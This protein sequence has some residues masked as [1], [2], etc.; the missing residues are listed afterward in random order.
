MIN[1]KTI[2]SS[3]DDK[4]TLLKWLKKV[5]KALAE[6]VLED[7]E[8]VT[9]D[10]THI[11]LVFKFE[12][13]TEIETSSITLPRGLKG[14]TGATGEAGPQGPQGPKGDDG[15]DAEVTAENV[16]AVT[17][18][19][20]TIVVD[21]AEDEEHIEIHLDADVVAKIENALQLPLNPPTTEKIVA[22]GTNGA[23]KLIDIPKLY[24]HNI[25]FK[26]YEQE[27]VN[28]M[29]SII[30]SKS[31]AYTSADFV[32]GIDIPLTRF[33]SL[34]SFV[35]SEVM[36]SKLYTAL[37]LDGDNILHLIGFES[38]PTDTPWFQSYHGQLI[39]TGNFF[40]DEVTEL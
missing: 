3:F 6:S 31:N 34:E 28:A 23:Q 25:K 2:L 39:A 8:V 30:S 19:S 17:E 29:I 22:I 14:D 7:V 36:V 5:E 38:N 40:E 9:I 16:L 10:A 13:E 20:E 35:A 4:E 33:I 15:S 37:D 24:L 27:Y 18:G 32:A 12:D 11:K 26:L 1:L 21:L